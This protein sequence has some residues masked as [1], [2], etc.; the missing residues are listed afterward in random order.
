MFPDYEAKHTGK[1]SYSVLHPGKY[2]QPVVGGNRYMEHSIQR[3]I[4]NR[5]LPCLFHMEKLQ[6]HPS[7]LER[8]TNTQ[9]VLSHGRIPDSAKQLSHMAE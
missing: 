6:V 4:V 9:Q 5:D 2:R 7:H 8:Y 3:S 1:P